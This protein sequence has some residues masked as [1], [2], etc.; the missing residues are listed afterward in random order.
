MEN[1]LLNQ[2]C[3]IGSQRRRVPTHMWTRRPGN[4]GDVRGARPN[5]MKINL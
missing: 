1:Q 5:R 2:Y 4:E 3:H